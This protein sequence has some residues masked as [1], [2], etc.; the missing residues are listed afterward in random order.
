MTK[1]IDGPAIG[2]TLMLKRTPILLRVTEL[3]GVFDAL[4]ELDDVARPEERLHCYVMSKYLGACH[5]NRSGG[6]GGFYPIAEYKLRE[7]PPTEVE[8]RDNA[9]WAKWCDSQPEAI[10]CE[11]DNQLDR[12]A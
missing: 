2:K 3:L 9:A 4:N 12:S 1:F 6:R 7:Q 5:I 8:M 10:K 11:A